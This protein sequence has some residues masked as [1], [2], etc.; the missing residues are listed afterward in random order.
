MADVPRPPGGIHFNDAEAG[1]AAAG[2]DAE[3][4]ENGSPELVSSCHHARKG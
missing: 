2:V 4:A 1:Q 3:D